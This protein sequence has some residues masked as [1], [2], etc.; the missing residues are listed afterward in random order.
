MRASGSRAARWLPQL[1][2]DDELQPRPG[3]VDGAHFDVDEPE[4]QGDFAHGVFGDVGLDLRG[5][6]RPRD[7]DRG[8]LL[9]PGDRGPQ[10]LVEPCTR[11]DEDVRDVGV[12]ELAHPLH[13]IRQRRQQFVV[14][15]RRS[16]GEQLSAGLD[17]ELLRERRARVA[18]HGYNV[19]LISAATAAWAGAPSVSRPAITPCRSATERFCETF[20]LPISCVTGISMPTIAPSN[21]ST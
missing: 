13:V 18:G 9:H 10:L 21:F 6:L 3:L 7:P 11:S 4:R 12:V 14:V 8:V 16:D 1:L 15:T 2:A 19:V 17:A 20:H 5:F